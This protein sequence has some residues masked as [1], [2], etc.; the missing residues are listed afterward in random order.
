M[1]LKSSQQAAGGQLST[2][3]NLKGTISS[4]LSQRNLLIMVDWPTFEPWTVTVE[5]WERWE[6]RNFFEYVHGKGVSSPK[7][8]YLNLKTATW[9]GIITLVLQRRKQMLRKTK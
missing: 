5:K 7:L 4:Y 6:E 2:K 1:S 8:S 3:D 9:A